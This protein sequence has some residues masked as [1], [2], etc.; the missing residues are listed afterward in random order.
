MER[1]GS[2]GGGALFWLRERNLF[3]DGDDIALGRIP[4]IES[5]EL[6]ELEI[7]FAQ[8]PESEGAHAAPGGGGTSGFESFALPLTLSYLERWDGGGDRF[9]EVRFSK[10]A[11][12]HRRVRF[13]FDARYVSYDLS[14]WSGE[15]EFLDLFMALRG[16]I[17]EDSWISIGLGVDPYLYD[18][19]LYRRTGY[20]R[21]HYIVERGLLDAGISREELLGSLQEAESALSE[22]WSIS[23]EAFV[24]FW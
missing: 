2:G 14:G 21:E 11:D 6:Y 20:G 3:L 12:L 19:W 10:G 18:G 9:S 16:R 22:E 24:R 17:G 15:R 23:F 5:D 4:F 1:Y 7:R 8:P 13:F